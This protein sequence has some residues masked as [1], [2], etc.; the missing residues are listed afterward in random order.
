MTK[1]VL[2]ADAHF[3]HLPEWRRKW[4]DEFIDKLI[5]LQDDEFSDYHLF[6]LGDVFE[7]RDNVDS[8][9]LNQFLKLVLNWK[10]DV[11]WITG[12]HDSYLPGLGTLEALSY[13]DNIF[14]CDREPRRLH[15]DPELWSVPFA[16]KDERYREMLAEVPDGATV[17][18]HLPIVEAIAQ[19][20]VSDVQGIKA[21]EFDRFDSVYSGDIHTPSVF[22][23]VRYIGAPSQRDWRDKHVPGT[24]GAYV[25]GEYQEFQTDP[26]RHIE[27]KN[28][29]DI[30]SEGRF[31]VKALEGC[32]I[33]PQERVLGV[34]YTQ[35]LNIEAIEF[36]S[37]H[38]DTDKAM[39]DYV[40]R[41]K[42]VGSKEETLE[43]GKTVM[44]TAASR[45]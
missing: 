38:V 5:A 14:V 20:G 7:I 22:K 29:R 9:V 34:T 33:R 32:T 4:N 28:S 2:L 12:Q 15:F 40:E 39:G 42:P 1:A 41:N 6:I 18:T 11:V 37:E 16:R 21:E 10:K 30:P 8:R 43:Y 25:D 45:A 19:F 27:V 23:K 26:V 36:S 17:F 35:Q 44:E 3:H 31:V 13:H 24:F